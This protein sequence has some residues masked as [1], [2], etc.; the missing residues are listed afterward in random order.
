[1]IPGS[2]VKHTAGRNG[3]PHSCLQEWAPA[4]SPAR[5][6]HLGLPGGAAG[7]MEVT[8]DESCAVYSAGIPQA[9]GPTFSHHLHKT[10]RN[11]LYQMHN[12]FQIAVLGLLSPISL[13]RLVALPGVVGLVALEGLLGCSS[14][15]YP[16]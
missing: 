1:M 6:Q 13:V 3:C 10:I 7:A 14:P 16:F 12:H 5:K 2:I 9:F 4:G 15:F 8:C 11:L